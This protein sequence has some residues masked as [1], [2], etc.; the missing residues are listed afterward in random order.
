MCASTRGF[1]GPATIICA[2]RART[3]FDLDLPKGY[4]IPLS[5][6]FGKVNT[7]S[8]GGL[9]YRAQIYV[10]GYQYGKYGAFSCCDPPQAS[11]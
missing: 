11:H 2:D 3:S 4:D 5:F 1:P 10:N 7:T 6:N 8:K 9:N